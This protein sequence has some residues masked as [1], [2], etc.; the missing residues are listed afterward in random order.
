MAS[1]ASVYLVDDD[2]SARKG[3]ARLLRTAGYDVRD[4]CCAKEFLG[5]VD[6]ETSGCLVLDARMPG[7]SGVELL[8]ELGK[9]GVQ[10]PIIMVTAEDDPLIKEVAKKLGAVGFFRKPV[11]G[12][13][14]M[15]AINWA[16]RSEQDPANSSD[17]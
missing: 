1:G 10:L 4:F 6:P 9:R 11:D 12:T 5:A 14:L 15:D 7:I 17:E 3:L 8:T 2:P 16:L 13:A